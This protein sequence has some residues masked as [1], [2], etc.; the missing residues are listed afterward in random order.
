MEDSMT[1]GI[2]QSLVG[3]R[4]FVTGGLVI[5]ATLARPRL[6]RAQGAAPAIV[7][8]DATRPQVPHGAMSGD[9]VADRAIVWSRTDRP[10]RMQVEWSTTDSFANAAQIRGPHALETSD[11]TA[12]LDL[13]GLPPGQEIFYRV[14]FLDLA[15]LRTASVPVVGRFRTAPASRRDLTVLWSGDTAGQ[16]YGINREW[17]GMKIYETM[18]RSN[19]DLFIHSGDTIYADGPIQA[20]VQLPGG[21]VW[22][23]VTTEE[24]SKVAETL[25][26]FRGNHKY[27]LLDENVRRF[28]SEVSQIW[29]WDDH[30]VTNNWS[31]SKTLAAD[32]RYTEKRVPLLI[33]RGA[34]AF[35][36]YAPMRTSPDESER[37]YRHIPYGPSLDVFVIDQR[38]YRGPNTFNRQDRAGPDTVY[39]GRPQLQWLKEGLLRSRATWKIIASD[40]PIGLLVG[41]GRDAEDRPRFE[42]IANGDGP[43]LGREMEIAELLRSIKHNN[44]R[45]VVWVTADTH[46]TA[47]HFYDPTKAQFTDF[48]PFWE[49]MSGPLNAG[50][51]GP[52]PPDNTFGI[53]VV[54]QKA[55]AA[56]QVNL[57]PSA[58]MQFFGEIKIDARSEAMSVNLRDLSGAALWQTALEPRRD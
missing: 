14:T 11:F 32:N 44:V 54:W 10:A 26:E 33:A 22:R 16:G 8:S 7:T 3:R 36:E 52:N 56:G 6:S 23:N 18:R 34:R 25:G 49:F 53:Q 51:F 15:D 24:K 57:P 40:M 30:E 42:A 28:N 5:G 20:E 55:P 58:G 41:D 37:I 43:A 27:N 31:S 19:A 12:R 35:L 45:N 38:S 4:G 39:L 2:K 50:T 13:H 47:A 48:D 29:Q 21:G 46:Y 9:V 1:S 17:G